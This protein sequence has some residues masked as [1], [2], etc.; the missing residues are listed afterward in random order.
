MAD[1]TNNSGRKGWRERV[2]VKNGMPKLADDFKTEPK[3]SRGPAANTTSSGARPAP[4][5]VAAPAPMAPRRPVTPAPSAPPRASAPQGSAPRSAPPRPAQARPAPPKPPSAP[6]SVKPSDA[7]GDRLRAQREAAE[8]LAAKRAQE[9]RDRLASGISSSGGPKF[10]FAEDELRAAQTEAAPVAPEPETPTAPAV[11]VAPSVAERPA[12][13][14]RPDLPVRPD[15]PA[16]APIGS[17]PAPRTYQPSDAYRQTH[18]YREFDQTGAPANVPP[19]APTRAPAPHQPA[20][21][22]RY[23]DDNAAAPRPAVPRPAAPSPYDRGPRSYTNAEPQNYADANDDLFE[24]PAARQADPR[25]ELRNEAPHNPSRAGASDYTAAYRDYDDA[26]DYDE[27]PRKKS[28]VWIFLVLMLLVIA[29]I[30][31]GAYWFINFGSKIGGAKPTSNVPTI[32]AP[33]KPV[34]VTPSAPDNSA[35][36][37]QVKRKKIYDRILGDQ[38]LEPEKL[39]PTEETPVQPVTPV[40]NNSGTDAPTGIE[41]LPLPLPPPPTV[42]GQQ[43]SLGGKTNKVASV[44]PAP[45][46]GQ[47]MIAP[48]ASRPTNTKSNQGGGQSAPL[49]LPPVAGTPANAPAPVSPTDIAQPVVPQTP[50]LKPAPLPRSKPAI[51]VARARQAAEQSRLAALARRA[52]PQFPT[53]GPAVARPVTPSAPLTGGGPVQLTPGTTGGSNFNSGTNTRAVVNQPAPT[54]PRTNIASLPQPT[55]PQTPQA[56]PSTGSGYVLQL[57]TFKSREGANAEYRR[58]VSRHSRLLSG[59]QPQITEADLGANG[60]FYK[61]RLGSLA[62]RSRAAGLCNSLI[63]SGEKDCLVRKQ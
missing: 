3:I 11:P 23:G 46:S 61:L 8:T 48:T 27:E 7:F 10:S 1:N 62:N 21:Y 15:L 44:M 16:R 18:G 47:T 54:R 26:F 63:A 4:R 32:T 51:I 24:R 60:K 22:D 58:L 28:G 2:G 34:K 19:R 6:V 17:R 36:P 38:T 37:G 55:Q 33:D 42:P 40:P 41:P 45:T 9:T 49:P 56:A 5:P 31:A 43:G 29:A 50:N 25:S 12:V 52:A 14:P 59:L 30:A 13:A 53:T 57:S 35:V 39:V 20:A